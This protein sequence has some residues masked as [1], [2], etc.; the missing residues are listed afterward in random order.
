MTDAGRTHAVLLRSP[1]PPLIGMRVR[2]Y[3]HAHRHCARRASQSKNGPRPCYASFV[4]E[5]LGAGSTPRSAR[6]GCWRS[7]T[8]PR[9][10]AWCAE[11]RPRLRGEVGRGA[12]SAR[13]SGP[14]RT[15]MRARTGL[16]EAQVAAGGDARQRA[17]GAHAAHRRA[18][19]R[20]ARE[21]HQAAGAGAVHRH[22]VQLVSHCAAQQQRSGSSARASCSATAASKAHR[23]R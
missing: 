20:L 12:G 8:G 19:G 22:V 21:G 16:D 3:K 17:A 7:R 18:R 11:H 1:I 10:T 2:R 13:C 15:R 6:T 23:R 5:V 9:T 14:G 4:A